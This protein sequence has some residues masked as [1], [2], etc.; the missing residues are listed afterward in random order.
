MIMA[1]NSYT[2]DRMYL[3]PQTQ[4]IIKA[5]KHTCLGSLPVIHGGSVHIDKYVS[6]M[7]EDNRLIAVIG[8]NACGVTKD[9][10]FCIDKHDAS[11]LNLTSE[12]S[13]AGWNHLHRILR[14]HF[15]PFYFE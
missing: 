12:N 7:V 4:H 8:S 15:T 2:R 11:A 9:G 3:N 1:L 14:L 6:F 10:D 13:R 5:E